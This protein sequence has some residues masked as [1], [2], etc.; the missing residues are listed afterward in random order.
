MVLENCLGSSKGS[1]LIHIHTTQELGT[2][3]QMDLV[4][5]DPK[6]KNCKKK[7]KSD[8]FDEL[9][10]KVYRQCQHEFLNHNSKK[11]NN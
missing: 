11:P 1:N 3:T 4:A 5:L 9:K 6:S 2:G 7:K 8:I 10:L